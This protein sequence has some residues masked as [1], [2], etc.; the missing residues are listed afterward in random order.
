MPARVRK[1]GNVFRVVEPSGALVTRGGSAVDGGG[2]NTRAE[3][4]AQATAINL[5][6]A[7]VP[8]PKRRKKKRTRSQRRKRFD[9]GQDLA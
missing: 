3:A 8:A 5:R 9:K 4:M 7:G 6:T 2:H 1:I